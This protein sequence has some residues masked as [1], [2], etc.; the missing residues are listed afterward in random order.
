MFGHMA[1]TYSHH[2]RVRLAASMLDM[3]LQPASGDTTPRK[4]DKQKSPNSSNESEPVR[5]PFLDY[6][7]FLARLTLAQRARWAAAIRLRA[8][9]DIVRL[10]GIVPTLELA[11]FTFAQRAFWAAEILALPAAEILPRGAVPFLYVAPKTERAAPIAFISLLN[12][13]C[14]CFNIFTTPPRF[15]IESPSQ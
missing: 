13:S 2:Q 5:A 6:A 14:S 9:G 15:V 7:V 12:R 11:P 4:R 1:W 3:D 10:L 8:A